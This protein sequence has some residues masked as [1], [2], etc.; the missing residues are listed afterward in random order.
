MLRAD[1]EETRVRLIYDAGVQDMYARLVESVGYLLDL[2]KRMQKL[3]NIRKLQTQLFENGGIGDS[4][5]HGMT[6]GIILA[7]NI[8][9]MNAIEGE[10]VQLFNADGTVNVQ[11]PQAE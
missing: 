7:Y 9:N 11:E 3:E 4:Y 6:N 5:T 10:E 8:I 1:I 2:E